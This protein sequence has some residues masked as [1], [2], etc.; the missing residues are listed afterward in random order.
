MTDIN[1]AEL[2][3]LNIILKNPELIYNNH[4]IKP[5]MFG[6]SIHTTISN[7][8]FE[9]GEKRNVPEITMLLTYLQSNDRLKDAG[10]AEY[11]NY[12]YNQSFVKENL[13]EFERIIVETFKTRQLKMLASQLQGELNTTSVDAVIENA[14]KGL[15]SISQ[16]TSSEQ[17]LSVDQI[18]HDAWNGLM[19]RVAHPGIRGV[20]TGLKHL[21]L[22]TGGYNKGAL[23]LIGGRPGSGKTTQLCNSALAVAKA[24]EPVLIFTLEMSNVQIIE[25]MISIETG[26]HYSDIRN[27]TLKKEQLEQISDCIRYFRTLPIYVDSNV[28]ANDAYF[29]SVTRK[30]HKEK[31]VRV[32]FFDYIQLGTE[33]DEGQMMALGK[34]SRTGKLL[35][36]DLN[37]TNVLY[38]QLS[39]SVEQ[40]DD[41]HPI[42]PDL[43]QSGNLEEDADVVGF[44][45]RDEY[46]Y[47]N[48]TKYKG[49]MEFI[50]AKHRDG[51][52]G[53]LFNTFDAP[54][55]RIKSK[56]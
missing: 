52:T 17:T 37:I 22:I 28:S 2:A 53:T 33:R 54:C 3:V 48:T 29:A 23:W 20:T 25:R 26:I 45:Y 10:G 42:L 40:R 32:T 24:D 27:G 21:D 8:M 14:K 46:Y 34:F 9:L 7:A 18:S 30:Y 4:S 5:F 19:E 6:S 39:R 55:L 36:K 35:A 1:Q 50:L 13:N 38:S 47:P 15:D 11:I 41:K 12:I 31:G 49:I 16:L 43:R 44:I 56:D 51:E